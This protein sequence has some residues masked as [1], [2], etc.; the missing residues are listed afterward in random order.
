ML[1]YL[2]ILLL[3]ASTSFI[4]SCGAGGGDSP[5]PKYS[6]SNFNAPQLVSPSSHGGGIGWSQ[7]NCIQCHS[8]DKLKS[9][10]SY[11]PNLYESF[12]NLGFE[13][14][15]ACL[16]CH[17]TNGLSVNDDSYE[18]ILCHTNEKAVKSP[19][20]LNKSHIHDITKDGNFTNSDCLLCHKTSDMNG[21]IDPSIDFNFKVKFSSTTEF[22]LN[23]HSPGGYIGIVPPLLKYDTLTTTIFET[24]NGIAGIQ[25]TAD[26]H[27]YGIGVGQR[28][29]TFRGSY[30][31]NMVVD[32]TACHNPHA[33]K[34]N[35]L[36]VENGET[37]LLTDDTAK[38]SEITVY[39]NNFSELC[40][41]CHKSNNLNAPILSN[42]LP[43]V[44]HDTPYSDNCTDCHYHGA[45]FSTK[46]D[47]LF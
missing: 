30:T 25:D 23:C 5:S 33:S 34:N 27:G 11:N 16:Y 6:N 40:A 39:G 8:A 41:V 13:H 20:N 4:I 21:K 17:N 3:L 44:V 26:V 45:G 38:K 12:K 32:C 19:L 22:C 28:F 2:N 43:E 9:I 36:I 14:I 15:G 24:F 7:S 35:Y 10:H 46:K 18:C 37:A 31:N 29:A 42:G 1:K 47:G